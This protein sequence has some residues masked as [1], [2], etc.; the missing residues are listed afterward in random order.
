MKRDHPRVTL[1]V[2]SHALRNLFEE[3]REGRLDLVIAR[4]PPHEEPSD[5]HGHTLVSQR[6][7]L[8]M[9]TQHPL[10]KSPRVG[11]QTLSE[12]AWIWHLPGTRSRALQDR[13]WHS[14]GLALPQ[15][16]IETGDQMLTLSLLRRIPCVTVLPL[17]AA[18]L[19]AQNGLAVI[20]PLD[21][22]L[23]LA[24]LTVWHLREPQSELTQQFIQHLHAAATEPD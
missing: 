21:A 17:H 13:L 6:E 24:D 16:V 20:L 18:R 4:V 9:S 1:S 10:A 11:W 3:L 2:R 15:N 22:N 23:G 19:A 12:Q 8:V 5:L 14:M 7:V